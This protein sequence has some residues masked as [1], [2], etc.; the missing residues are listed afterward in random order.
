MKHKRSLVTLLA[1]ISLIVGVEMWLMLQPS[2]NR[3]PEA[4]P[5]S[6]HQTIKS[7]QDLEALALSRAQ[8]TALKLRF[9]PHPQQLINDPTD[10]STLS[11]SALILDNPHA[12]EPQIA[13][14]LFTLLYSIK[15]LNQNQIPEGLNVEITN[16]LLGKNNRKIGYI[17]VDIP[18]I[19]SYGQLV[20]KQGVPFWIHLS[21]QGH[22]EITA[23]GPDQRM[24]TEDDIAYEP[25]SIH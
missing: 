2:S 3:S 21:S 17:P 24:H 25:T 9:I 10:R 23:A 11:E 6:Q 14:A 8:Q 19:N 12:T 7:S 1:T 20:D 22:L 15:H 13:N 16:A 4:A 5:Y 18:Y